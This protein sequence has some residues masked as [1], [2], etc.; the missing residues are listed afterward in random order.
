ARRAS[1]RS[2][3]PRRRRPPGSRPALWRGFPQARAKPK[4]DRSVFSLHPP[5]ASPCSCVTALRAQGC[6]GWIAPQTGMLGVS[7]NLARRHLLQGVAA[8]SIT[9][10]ALAAC[11]VPQTQK[12][13]GDDVL[14][15]L[16]AVGV[17]TL[18]RNKEITPLE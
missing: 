17:A 13:T 12:G 4:A 2:R 6:P 5:A 7:M 9:G 11:R 16:D 1:A 18:V 10:G 3:H 8:V 14:G 15:S